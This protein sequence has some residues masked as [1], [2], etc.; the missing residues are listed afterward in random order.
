MDSDISGDSIDRFPH[1]GVKLTERFEGFAR[2][3]EE[4]TLYGDAAADE[5]G[6]AEKARAA[7]A[8]TATKASGQE[9]VIEFDL[10]MGWGG[11]EGGGGESEEGNGGVGCGM[12]VLV[13]AK[14]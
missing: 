14:S 6:S 7:A 4:K 10:G 5:T 1:D 13:V 3:R 11:A 9:F 2:K 12:C 8:T